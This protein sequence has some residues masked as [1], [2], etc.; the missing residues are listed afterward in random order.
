MD[1]EVNLSKTAHSSN[2][3]I[4]PHGSGVIIALPIAGVFWGLVFG[5]LAWWIG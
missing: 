5:V 4:V 3:R 1:G 2:D